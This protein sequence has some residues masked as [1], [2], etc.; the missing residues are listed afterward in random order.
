MQ[1]LFTIQ[2]NHQTHDKIIITLKRKYSHQE[3]TQHCYPQK[4]QTCP[5]HGVDVTYTKHDTEYHRQHMQLNCSSKIKTKTCDP[6]RH[7]N[8]P[9]Y[10]V[11]ITHVAHDVIPCT[12]FCHKRLW[13]TA[14]KFKEIHECLSSAS[15]QVS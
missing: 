14:G 9:N 12:H 6:Q 11:Y 10:G 13:Q 5:N 1:L 4:L 15:C 7:Q 8:K 3:K 2:Q